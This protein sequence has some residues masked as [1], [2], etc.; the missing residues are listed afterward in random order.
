MISADTFRSWS[1][2]LATAAAH[3]DEQAT[4]CAPGSSIYLKYRELAESCEA[5]ADAAADEAEAVCFACNGSGSDPGSGEECE[6]C[7]GSGWEP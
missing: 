7:A 3:F 4:A 6:R 2:L 1:R 5:A